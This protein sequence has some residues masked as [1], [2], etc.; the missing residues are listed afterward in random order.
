[1]NGRMGDLVK[2]VIGAFGLDP[3]RHVF[4]VGDQLGRVF[5]GVDALWR[6]RRMR[7]QPAHVDGE[8]ALALVAGDHLHGCRL[9][10]DAHGR[11]DR[12]VL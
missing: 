9:A 4:E 5:D 10:D 1:M 11:A 7:L 2:L 8:A 12:H 6:Q 3:P